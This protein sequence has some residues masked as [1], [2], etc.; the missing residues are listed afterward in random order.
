MKKDQSTEPFEIRKIF[1][2]KWNHY[3]L[4]MLNLCQKYKI[5]IDYIKPVGI[6]INLRMSHI[7]NGL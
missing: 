6:D 4:F 7:V 1:L 5:H 3:R 2:N